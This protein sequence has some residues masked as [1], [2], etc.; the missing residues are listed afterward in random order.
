MVKIL[1]GRKDSAC[2]DQN[3]ELTPAYEQFILEKVEKVPQVIAVISSYPRTR[4]TRHWLV[5]YK[6]STT[7]LQ[8]GIGSVEIEFGKL[9]LPKLVF[10]PCIRV[11]CPTSSSERE[12]KMNGIIVKTW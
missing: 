7:V 5:N 10:G 11:W 3:L 9:S 2:S 4:W 12:G 1:V 6:A 8:T